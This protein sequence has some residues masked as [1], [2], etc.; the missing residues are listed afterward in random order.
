[1]KFQPGTDPGNVNKSC[2]LEE[3][4]TLAPVHEHLKCPGTLQLIFERNLME[5][6]KFAKN[7]KNSITNKAENN[8]STSQ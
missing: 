4:L 2:Y 8:F 7:L 3:Y 1:M 5:D 6:P